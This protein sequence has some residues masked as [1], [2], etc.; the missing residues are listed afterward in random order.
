MKFLKYLLSYLVFPFSFLVP[1]SRKMIAFG[2]FRGGF[3]GNANPR[4]LVTN[5][6]QD[7]ESC[8]QRSDPALYS[9]TW[10]LNNSTIPTFVP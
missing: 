2:S 8:L 1:R 9:C 5:A 10:Q 4:Q 7:C 6:A 3:D